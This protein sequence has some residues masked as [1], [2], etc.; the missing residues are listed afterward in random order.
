MPS[1][2]Y[3]PVV[4]SAVL[5]GG[6]PEPVPVQ[7][8]TVTLGAYGSAGMV[9]ATTAILSQGDTTLPTGLLA[10]MQQQTQTT[11]DVY[12]GRVDDPTRWGTGDLTHVFSGLVDL[13]QW[14]LETNTLTIRGRDW[15]SLLMDART[16]DTYGN[17]TPSAIATLFAQQV[18]LAP[19][20]TPWSTQAGF[21]YQR[22]TVHIGMIPRQKWDLLLYLARSIGFDV[23]VTPERQL[24]FG[25]PP[26][27]S[28]PPVVFS[29]MTP[30]APLGQS[31]LTCKITHS[32]RRNQTFRVLVKSYHPKTTQ[33]V[34]GDTIVLGVDVA[35]PT[36]RTLRAGT[37]R[38]QGP[39]GSTVYNELAA[40]LEGKPVF[41]FVIP[42]LTPQQAQDRAEA[43]AADI[44]RRELVVDAST[45]G[46][47]GLTTRSVIQF[48]GIEHPARPA[49]WA[50]IPGGMDS[51]P[52]YPQRVVHRF[53]LGP[54]ATAAGFVTE[55]TAL[56]I[57][58]SAASDPSEALAAP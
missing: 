32:P 9:T 47:P 15:S 28:V 52:F 12:V 1:V 14:E 20:V 44:A 27:P 35:L 56:T 26:A 58:Q 6:L 57:P 51:R 23:Y 30:D 45:E 34:T 10:L 41:E 2:A 18:G 33:V 38:G 31:L 13:T 16:N 48:R 43:I 40:S 7:S 46:T 42:G 4:R 5:L 54:G 53:T 3:L 37:Y 21:Y 39:A 19:Q 25:P 36:T 22:D 29:W 55:F 49:V 11:I 8:W 17:M 50:G 24:Y